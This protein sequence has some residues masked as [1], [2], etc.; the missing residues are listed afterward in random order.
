M[1]FAILKVV[2]FAL[3][4]EYKKGF[5]M[6]VNYSKVCLNLLRNAETKCSHALNSGNL[7][8]LLKI[9]RLG[10]KKHSALLDRLTVK[11]YLVWHINT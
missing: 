5:N 7:R 3:Q 9:K 4:I 1:Y 10:T 6:N 2:K 11:M 8:V